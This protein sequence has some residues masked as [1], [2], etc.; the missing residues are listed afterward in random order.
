MITRLR[1]SA[2]KVY[3]LP[4][5]HAAVGGIYHAVID[6]G[7]AGV[8]QADAFDGA[9]LAAYLNIVADLERMRGQQ[10]YAGKEVR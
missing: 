4:R 2:E 1:S 10:R 7:K 5:G 3:Y 8:K 9:A 6:C